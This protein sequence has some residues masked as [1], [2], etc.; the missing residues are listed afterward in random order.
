M[1]FMVCLLLQTV[2]FHRRQ[3]ILV[4][5]EHDAAADPS[6]QV[7]FPDPLLVAVR[8]LPHGRFDLKDD[9][10]LRTANRWREVHTKVGEA[11]LKI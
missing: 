2:W 11:S 8:P 3:A 10:K 5:D 6:V 4:P 1:L 9:V 7:A